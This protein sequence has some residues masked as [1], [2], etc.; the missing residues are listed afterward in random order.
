MFEFLLQLSLTPAVLHFSS[1]H[2]TSR[3]MDVL[4]LETF[5]AEYTELHSSPPANGNLTNNTNGS[6]GTHATSKNV[7]RI[8]KKIDAGEREVPVSVTT[9]GQMKRSVAKAVEDVK[10]SLERLD[11]D[12]KELRKIEV[13]FPSVCKNKV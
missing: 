12:Y 9:L 10:H 5:M 3:E 13:C 7:P 11:S 1:H 2:F 4:D 6:A 8:R